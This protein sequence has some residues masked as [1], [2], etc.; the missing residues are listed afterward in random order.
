MMSHCIPIA[1]G[2]P[3]DTKDFE[4]ETHPSWNQPVD[5]RQKHAE[6][7]DRGNHHRCGRDHIILAR[8][9]YLLHFHAHV[10]HKFA[11]VRH[12]S[13]D[14]LAD[15]CGRSGNSVAAG[16]VVFHFY[17]L[18]SHE[19]LFTSPEQVSFPLGPS[20][21]AHTLRLSLPRP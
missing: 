14:S 16:L 6:E 2:S 12:R 9:G 21:S 18:R 10:V 8:P 7:K 5:Y 17:R 4:D 20:D 13:R 19:T 11:R 15:A 1:V 3:S